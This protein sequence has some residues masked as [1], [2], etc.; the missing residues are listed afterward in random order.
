MTTITII[1]AGK[2]IYPENLTLSKPSE[3]EQPNDTTADN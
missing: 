2:L 3:E 1:S